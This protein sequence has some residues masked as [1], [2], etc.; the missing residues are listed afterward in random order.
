MSSCNSNILHITVIRRQVFN[1]MVYGSADPCFALSDR[2]IKLQILSDPKNKIG[3][4]IIFHSR[5]LR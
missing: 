1:S 5:R 3:I 4:S 2:K